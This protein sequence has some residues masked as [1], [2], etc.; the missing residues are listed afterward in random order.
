[1]QFCYL[2]NIVE[3]ATSALSTKFRASRLAVCQ[4]SDRPT[5][6]GVPYGKTDTAHAR[7]GQKQIII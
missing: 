5:F 3:I 2:D 7:G 1:M 4:V 6:C